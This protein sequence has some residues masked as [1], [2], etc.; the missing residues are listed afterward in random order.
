MKG[1]LESGSRR[2][3]KKKRRKSCWH[4]RSRTAKR[5]GKK[6]KGPLSGRVDNMA[7]PQG[8]IGD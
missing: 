8:L 5:G 6:K 7:A 4:S 1:C 2:S 3:I